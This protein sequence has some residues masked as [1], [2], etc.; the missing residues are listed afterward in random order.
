M[1]SQTGKIES[2]NKTDK[3][4]VIDGLSKKLAE[5]TWK[6]I[7][8]LVLGGNVH[9]DCDP[10]NPSTIR[11]IKSDEE[12]P[13]FKGGGYKFPGGNRQPNFYERYNN[14][15]KI[16]ATIVSVNKPFGNPYHNYGEMMDD[17]KILADMIDA[18]CREKTKEQLNR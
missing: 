8:T 16:A 10:N 15:L 9:Y 7:D 14:N 1:S 4:V 13:A 3:T 2:I 17:I 11:W 18:Y 6:W 12:K 5:R